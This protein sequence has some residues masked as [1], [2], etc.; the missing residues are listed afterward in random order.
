M[1]GPAG[2][3]SLHG[4]LMKSFNCDQKAIQ[5]ATS[6]RVPDTAGEVLTTAQQLSESRM[7][8]YTKKSGQIKLPT[9]VGMK[10]IQLQEGD[11]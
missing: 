5:W 6:S 4:D 7:E 1:L 3:L 8:I 2:V 10:A 9:K 11:S